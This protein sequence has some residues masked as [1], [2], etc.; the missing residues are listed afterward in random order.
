LKTIETNS[1]KAYCAGKQSIAQ[2]KNTTALH[3]SQVQCLAAPANGHTQLCYKF[4]NRELLFANLNW[5]KDPTTHRALWGCHAII[6]LLVLDIIAIH[7][8]RQHRAVVKIIK[9]WHSPAF[10][11]TKTEFLLLIYSESVYF[12]SQC[13]PSDSST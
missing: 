2:E 7:P 13:T 10:T 4:E 12:A 5:T 11:C 1:Q 9:N 6:K 8:D 3:C